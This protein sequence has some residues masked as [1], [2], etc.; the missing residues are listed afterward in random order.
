M[1]QSTKYLNRV[2]SFRMEVYVSIH[3]HSCSDILKG[4]LPEGTLCKTCD[5]LFSLSPRVIPLLFSCLLFLKLAWKM[6]SQFPLTSCSGECV[7]VCMYDTLW[8]VCSDDIKNI[9]KNNMWN[10]ESPLRQK[11]KN[12]ELDKILCCHHIISI[13]EVYKYGNWVLP[14]NEW[15]IWNS[16]KT[17][18]MEIS[19]FL[20][21]SYSPCSLSFPLLSPFPLPF[22]LSPS[23]STSLSLS[24][25]PPSPL[26]L[27]PLSSPFF[28]F[29]PPLPLLSRQFLAFLTHYFPFT[30]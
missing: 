16:W 15:Q 24:L 2:I 30:N 19:L 5:V 20:F 12:P 13:K 26:P 18:Q 6:L 4:P 29:R 17:R 3:K 9:C 28:F 22:P 11:K 1:Q 8:R 23:L 10:P 21:H 14:N 27:L 7:P 25:P